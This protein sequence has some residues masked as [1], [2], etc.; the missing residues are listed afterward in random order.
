MNA[1]PIAPQRIAANLDAVNARI[2]AAAH[3]VGRAPEDI[4]LVPITKTVG[5]EE[6]E[7]L[8]RLGITALGENRTDVAREKIEVLGHA[9]RWHMI[10][11]VQRR[12]AKDVAALFDVVDAVDRVALAEALQRR[13]DQAGREL[14]AL[15][16]VNVSGEEAKHG[17]APEALE[18]ALRDMRP[19][20]R[21]RIEGLMTM[22]PLGADEPTIRRIFRRL[23][24]LADGL[25]LRE[26]SMGMTNDFEIAVEE[27]ATQ[28]R[29]GRA[30][31][32]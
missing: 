29:I 32:M 7:A 10:G 4:C 1:V 14:T 24:E 3:R 11:N 8:S 16:E 18:T 5:V 22:A 30:L 21:L 27:G 12:K 19:L 15:A 25:G 13:C 17:F 2:A 6:A 9:V 20:D 23:K 31:F 26:V 28:L